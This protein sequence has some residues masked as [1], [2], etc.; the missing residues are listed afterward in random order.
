MIEHLDQNQII[1]I[2]L[3]MTTSAVVVGFMAG[4]FGI[5]G[6]V[7]SR[8]YDY[9][10][11]ADV[12]FSTAD[13]GL[14]TDAHHPID[15]AI[16]YGSIVDPTVDGEEDY[17][18][19]IYTQAVNAA[20]GT[21]TVSG[22]G[23]QAFAFGVFSGTGSLFSTGGAAESKSST[24]FGEDTS[25]GDLSGTSI[26]SRTFREIG[27]GSILRSGFVGEARTYAYNESSSLTFTTD[28]WDL[29]QTYDGQ[30]ITPFDFGSVH[31]PQADG[32]ED[33]GSV[34]YTTATD[35]TK[36]TYT[37]NGNA[38]G[39]FLRAPY[40]GSG[41]LFT[42]G[43]AA[44]VV[45]MD[46]EAIG[47]FDIFT[48]PQFVGNTYAFCWSYTGSGAINTL[49]GAAE[50]RTWDYSDTLPTTQAS[51]DY[52]LVS[53]QYIEFANYG[54]LGV[55][56]GGEQDFGEDGTLENLGPAASGTYTLSGVANTPFTWRG[57]CE[58][59]TFTISGAGEE[60]F[61]RFT[62]VDGSGQYTIYTA[63]AS[64]GNT[65]AFTWGHGFVQSGSLFS[66]GGAA[67]STTTNPPET[68]LLYTVAGTR[69]SERQTFAESGSGSITLSGVGSALYTGAFEGS[70]LTRITILSDERRTFGNFNGSG[71]LFT[72][73]GAAESTSVSPEGTGI[74]TLSGIANLNVVF[75]YFGSGSITLSGEAD[76][77]IA[78]APWIGSGSITLSGTKAESFTPATEIGSGSLFTAS[79]AAEAFT[80]DYE[81]TTLYTVLGNTHY[82]FSLRHI[83]SGSL[84]STGGAVEV[85]GTN[86]PESTVLL[87]P[88]GQAIEKH[89]ENYVGSGSISTT[90][91][92]SSRYI[93]HI[94]G[95]GTATFSGEA[96]LIY[97]VRYF[98]SGSLFTA[99]GAS[100]SVTTNP[101]ESTV[102]LAP[103]GT[104]TES[105]VF[106]NNIGSGSIS[107]SGDSLNRYI[108][109]ITGSGT[110]TVSGAA[111]FKLRYILSGSGNIFTTVGAA[112][113]TT[114]NPPEDTALFIWSGVS[115][116]AWQPVWVGQG[117]YFTSGQIPEPLI[118]KHWTASG[119]LFSVGGAA[120]S[121]S[122][123]IDGIGLYDISGIAQTP[124]AR[125]FVGTGSL[126]TAAGAAEAVGTNPPESTVLFEYAGT[127]VSEKHV[128]RWVG[129]FAQYTLSG[130]IPEPLITKSWTG[131]GSI[132][133]SGTAVE[134]QTDDWVGSGSLFTAGGGAESIS[135]N[136]PESTLLFTTS[137]QSIEKHVERYVGDTA[138]YTT[139]GEAS[140]RFTPSWIGSGSLFE[141][142]GAVES[143][144]T[145][146]F[147][148]GIFAVTGTVGEAF[149]R[150]PYIGSGSIT[151]SGT[152]PSSATY[153]DQYL[154][155]AHYSISG[156]ATNI[157][158]GWK[159][160]GFYGA[161]LFGQ[162]VTPLITKHQTG[163]GSLFTAGGTAESITTNPPENTTLH[164]VSGDSHI[165]ITLG[166]IGSGTVT[167]SGTP[168]KVVYLPNN[169]G[170]GSIF[171]S[172]IAGEAQTDHYTGSGTATISGDDVNT[173]TFAHEGEG[174]LF[175]ASGAAES[176]TVDWETYYLF[177]VKGTGAEAFVRKGY[178]GSGVVATISGE[179]T[180]IKLTY[181]PEEDAAQYTY[182]GGV[183]DVKRTAHWV[184]PHARLFAF[185]GAVET[186]TV[187]Y[188]DTT[189]YTVHGTVADKFV[190]AGYIGQGSI[191]LTGDSINELRTFE[192]EFVFAE[193]I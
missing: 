75:N 96:N 45:A 120:E 191:T 189:L 65:Y 168:E 95:S 29:V 42:A 41:S 169:I 46:Y 81:D 128:E 108:P 151:L 109:C 8:T 126:F 67:E 188:E 33:W 30:V 11:S 89:T 102:L 114:S 190:R 14:V 167:I 181:D 73:S 148:T 17:E 37:F 16:E 106:A 40:Q 77:V 88:T 134:R 50:S 54:D 99:A 44:E 39:R 3:V 76:V 1:F 141:A 131:S 25:L 58:G 98:G 116:N 117:S 121:F 27:S 82:V 36:G 19:V 10:D 122:A 154:Q 143:I 132:S 34:L 175:T 86:P 104:G 43:G 184:A 187:D 21:Y 38:V 178:V 60:R 52:G 90:G 57:G 68:T 70:G 186:A 103:T 100:E 157:S 156:E 176:V 5:G 180:D 24:E 172:G 153:I 74:G 48:A 165:V 6:C 72:A 146:E 160:E 80:L 2:I 59:G 179:A 71:S 171:I 53:N 163:S 159:A 137:G 177:E 85:V 35:A 149:A 55:L 4:L 28:D 155:T 79:G 22:V 51:A 150:T 144:S 127:R 170:S 115:E 15:D 49:S 111:T 142:S 123:N 101:P 125:N 9:N 133:L 69:I 118:T 185:N 18:S 158:L 164:K 13:Y 26:L 12:S 173:R 92:A 87:A 129:D 63:P 31:P 66:A 64:V 84:F 140:V 124:R 138:Q 182:S 161:F 166:H 20:E 152:S 94:T 119:S 183:T 7:E 91:V 62:V 112:E 32:E 23:S 83:G 93:P 192:P 47:L 107:L 130:A 97:R 162:T 110:Y 135:T 139:S 145:S 113:S 78:R 193:I 174:S 56:T 136:I 147:T 105:R 61:A